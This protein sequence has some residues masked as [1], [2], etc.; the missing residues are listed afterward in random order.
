MLFRSELEI[1]PREL[2]RRLGVLAHESEEIAAAKLRPGE[3]AEIRERLEA[4]KHGEAIVRGALLVHEALVG[5]SGGARDAVAAA[6]RAARE[7]AR[8]DG[9]FDA[10]ATRLAGIAAEVADAAEEARSLGEELEHD[11]A[12]LAALE[13]RVSL[14]YTLERRYGEDE[15]AV[16][17]YGERA[18]EEALRLRGL[19]EDRKSTRLNSSH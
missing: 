12:A 7:V 11:P 6:E 5:E 2:E 19:D 4:A 9:R 1:D 3:A 10:L 8:V 15:A 13:E 14:I 17:A 18:A 16:I